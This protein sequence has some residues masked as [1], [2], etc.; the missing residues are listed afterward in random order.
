M[1]DVYGALG[2]NE[3]EIQNQ[4]VLQI[5]IRIM[6]LS[7]AKISDS[8]ARSLMKSISL[9]VELPVRIAFGLTIAR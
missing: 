3:D 2:A 9:G 7:T 4:T 5:H 8:Q 6:A 1:F